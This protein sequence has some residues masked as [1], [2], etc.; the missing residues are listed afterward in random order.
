MRSVQRVGGIRYLMGVLLTL[1]LAS[2]GGGDDGGPNEWSVTVTTSVGSGT[3]VTVDGTNRAAPFNT[4]WRTGESHTIGVPSPQSGE[5]GTRYLFDRWSDGGAQSHEVMVERSRTFTATLSTEH[6]L[7]VTATP[8]GAGTVE[9]DPAGTWFAEGTNVQLTA[10]PVVGWLFD[11]WEGDITGDASPT[12]FAMDGPKS[13]TAVFGEQPGTVSGR[14]TQ[15]WDDAPLVGLVVHL[16]ANGDT[17][18]TTSDSNGE[19]EFVEVAV[20]AY[21]V[22]ADAASVIPFG[23]FAPSRE[24]AITLGRG[25]DVTGVDFSYQ[26]AEIEVRTLAD[27]SSVSVGATVTITLEL[28]LSAIPLPASTLT[29]TVSWDEAVAD[30]TEGSANAAAWDDLE[31]NESPLG[32][33]GFAAISINGVGDAVVV[34]L[35]YDVVA[36][37]IGATEF[38]PVLAELSV[39][40]PA[41]GGAV[42]LLSITTVVETRASVSVQ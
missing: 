15:Q 6:E 19:Y 8:D 35:T 30:Y 21:T 38:D 26:R 17:L 14:A 23:Q 31:I 5:P 13:V 24:Q 9:A 36:I 32:T 39:I 4:Q 7:T 11:R 10:S 33:L 29:G 40:D 16:I 42:D 1:G 25:E 22:A 18:T 12:S 2:C 20:G 41:T 34:G 28:D 37:D 27:A 3:Q